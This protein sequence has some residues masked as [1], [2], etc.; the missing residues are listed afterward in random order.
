VVTYSFTLSGRLL[1]QVGQELETKP[2]STCDRK[3]AVFVASAQK[4]LGTAVAMT[5][6]IDG[7]MSYGE[8]VSSPDSRLLLSAGA[9][10]AALAKSRAARDLNCIIT[11]CKGIHCI[12]FRTAEENRLRDG[13]EETG[14]WGYN[15]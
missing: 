12:R 5:A 4:E 6:I 7:G 15:A 3:A 8:S 14:I 13:K 2:C 9:A 11:G 1:Y 10:R